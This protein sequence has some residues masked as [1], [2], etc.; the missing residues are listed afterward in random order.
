MIFGTYLTAPQMCVNQG[1]TTY[2]ERYYINDF[3]ML[4]D[5]NT[6]LQVGLGLHQYN[7][8]KRHMPSV[9]FVF[10]NMH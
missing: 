4:S 7:V 2:L 9:G 5:I 3:N 1:Q 6:R 8:S 10:Q